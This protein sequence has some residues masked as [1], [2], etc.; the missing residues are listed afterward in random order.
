MINNRSIRF[1]AAE[2]ITFIYIA[3]TF[4]TILFLIPEIQ[5]VTKLL[6]YRLIF[7]GLIVL[8]AYYNSQHNWWIIKFLR[9]AFLGALIPY[10]YPETFEINRAL[11]NFD[12]LLANWEQ[13]IFGFQPALLFCQAFPERHILMQEFY[14]F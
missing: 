9:F 2:K 12:F 1:F 10:W 4:I 7:V 6:G 8:F 13:N 14:V 3:V 5:N 11:P